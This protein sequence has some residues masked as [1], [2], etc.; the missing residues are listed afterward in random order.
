MLERRTRFG[1]GV[2]SQ[3]PALEAAASEANRRVLEQHVSA[4]DA[5]AREIGGETR[6][7]SV[8]KKIRQLELQRQI[9]TAMMKHGDRKIHATELAAALILAH[10]TGEEKLRPFF[11]AA[12]ALERKTNDSPHSGV[13]TQNFQAIKNDALYRLHALL[14]KRKGYYASGLELAKE[15][16]IRRDVVQ[17]AI[18]LLDLAGAVHKLPTDSQTASF[19]WT[20]ASNE[21]P[22]PWWNHPYEVL[23]KMADYREPVGRAT[24]IKKG[25]ESQSLLARGGKS[26]VTT[27]SGIKLIFT[28]LEHDGLIQQKGTTTRG[29]PLFSLTKETREWVE[30]T[31]R[32]GILDER[33]RK[34]LLGTLEMEKPLLQPWREE[35]ILREVR[36]RLAAQNQPHAT[37]AYLASELGMRRQNAIGYLHRG[38]TTFRNFRPKRILEIANYFEEKGRNEEADYLRRLAAAKSIGLGLAE[39]K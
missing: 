5:E 1:R 22:E 12:V 32:T 15:L 39:K 6:T 20:H 27:T 18:G 25:K 3:S 2:R 10:G 29:T 9:L 26:P 11:N 13:M 19:V 34:A 16:K 14:L 28:R 30:E 37:V 8:E 17:N 21:P 7:Q 4:V 35:T 33:L 36:L 31:K 24:F 23:S 38:V